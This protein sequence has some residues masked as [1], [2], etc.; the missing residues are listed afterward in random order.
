MNDIKKGDIV[1]RK[2]YGKD[3]IF[4]VI[5]I[6][7]KPEEKIAVLNGVIERIEADSKIADLELVDKQKVKDILRKM[8]SKIENRIEKSKQQWEDRNYRIGVVTNQT[9]AKEKI[10]TGEILHLDGDR[11]YS[12]KSYRY[13]RKLG[14]NAIVKYIPEYRQP[15]V[16]YQ[17]LESYNPDIL[18]ITGHDGMIKRGMRYNDI[19]NYRNSRYFIET[20]KE[21]RK[22]DKQ[23]GKKL[24][25]FAGACQSYFE[26]LINAGANFASSPARVLLDF[27]DPLIVAE[28]IATT[29]SD[30]YIT[31]NDIADDLR[32]GKDGVGGIGAKGKKQKVTLM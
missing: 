30:C 7:N 11:K 32:D 3:I 31:I 14:L 2:S 10:I 15:R 24:V 12:E 9:R 13:Y 23:K 28:K 27:A 18:V 4:R 22:Y 8:D 17:L 20:V 5:N 1:V 6:L 19:Y 21:A 16:V 25:I 29:D 26:A